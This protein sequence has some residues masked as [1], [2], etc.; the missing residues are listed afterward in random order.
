MLQRLPGLGRVAAENDDRQ[1]VDDFI[2]QGLRGFDVANIVATYET[3]IDS[4]SWRHGAGD[5]GLEVI[6]NRLNVSFSMSDAISRIQDERSSGEG[7]L[8]SDIV[9]GILLSDMEEVDF[10]GSYV[11][12]G[13]LAVC[14]LSEKSV[15]GL[16]MSGCEIGVLNIF[17]SDVRDTSISHSTVEVLDGT[18]G[19]GLPTWISDCAIGSQTT[20]DTVARIKRS[21]LRASE[22][23]LVTIL[24]KT[25]FQPG[26]GRKED[27]SLPGLGTIGDSKL[28][29]RVLNV[30]ISRSFLSEAPGRS[31]KIVCT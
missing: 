12:N 3:G 2:V 4:G 20:L 1:F 19:E 18:S 5:L 6:A 11:Q 7:P 10:S 22:I 31:G 23:I 29:S 8:H 27:A 21:P 30:L 26:S 13:Y 15:V 25:F 28:Q 17:N 14:D 24:R 16:H 9:G